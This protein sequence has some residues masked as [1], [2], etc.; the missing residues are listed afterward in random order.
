MAPRKS[1]SKVAPV[2][3]Q[4]A[5]KQMKRT[6]RQPARRARSNTAVI[7][8]PVSMGGISRNLIPHMQQLE[9]GLH[10]THSENFS[11]LP[12][13]A[14]GALAYFRVALIPAT[15]PYLAGLGS[16]FGK[17]KW[18][19]LRLR[20][21]PSCPATTEGESALG[22]VFDRQ[23]AAAATFNQV[24]SSAHAISFPPWG[25]FSGSASVTIEVDCSQFD[26]NR[27]SYM[28]VAAFNALGASDQNNYCPVTLITATQ[29]ST[30][31]VPVGGRIWADYSIQLTDPIVPGI[32]A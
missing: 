9:N 19:R 1:Q 27:Y 5:R 3:M 30:L 8:A 20:Y 16:N 28:A 2:F 24:T 7:S 14:L 11:T 17:F 22:L 25:G 32:N 26:K 13:T 18:T 23:D 10:V 31:A 4:V 15:M 12:L 6:N 21:V 29:G